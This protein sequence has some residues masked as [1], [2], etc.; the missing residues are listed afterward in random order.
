MTARKVV[1]GKRVAAALRTGTGEVGAK[2]FGSVETIGKLMKLG[3][4]TDPHYS[5][6]RGNSWAIL[7][8]HGAM[9]ATGARMAQP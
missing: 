8:E 3:A 1:L 2:V 6:S 7:T 5:Y 4:V 9:L